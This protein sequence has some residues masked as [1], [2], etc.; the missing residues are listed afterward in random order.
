M[1]EEFKSVEMSFQ[2]DLQA[3]L[4]IKELEDVKIQ[5]LGKK[6]RLSQFMKQLKQLSKDEKIEAGKNVNRLKSLFREQLDQQKQELKKIEFENRMQAEWI[7]ITVDPLST[8]T[9]SLHPVSMVQHMLEDIFV[10]MGFQV[11]DGPHIET[12]F[13][14]FE[15]LNIA[16]HHPARDLQ[17]TF[18]F[19][20]G[21]LL[22]THTSTIQIRGME[23]LE[24]PLRIVG[25]GKVFRCE[26][27]DASH[28]ACFHQFEGMMIDKDI[29]VSHLIY[30]MKTMLGEIFQS[31]VEV[32]LRPGYFPFVEPGFELDLRC[33]LCGGEGCKACKRVGWIELM[34]CGMVHPNVLRA[35]KID[36]D[37]YSGFAFGMGIDRLA[38]MKY[39]ITDIRPMHGGQME[40]AQCFSIE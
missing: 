21:H 14:N 15:A 5:Y 37:I 6:G 10:A 19:E 32:R 28:D 38:M 9:G 3:A 27:N 17:D 8:I 1:K 18:Y 36:P 35:G 13:Y 34:G 31:D 40:F 20:D 24:P 29:T 25:P 12:E 16:E 11:L 26:R 7:D 4:S 30:F 39:D 22:R 2:Q 23:K 33:L